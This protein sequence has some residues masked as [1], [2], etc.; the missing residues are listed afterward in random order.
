MIWGRPINLWTGLL[1]LISGAVATTAIALGA[2]PVMVA[3]LIGPWTAVLGA[4]IL[5]VANQPATIAEGATYTVVTADPNASN[6][7]KVANSNPT[8]PSIEVPK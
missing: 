4:V 7:Q 2:D 5:F 8:P 1:T 3:T 6:V